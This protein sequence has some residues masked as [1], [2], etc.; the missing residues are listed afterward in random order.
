VIEYGPY[1]ALMMAAL[2]TYLSRAAGV[3]L[4]E[5]LDPRSPVMAWFGCIAYALVAAL[6]ARLILLPGGPLETTSL[7]A[8]LL[9][10]G[11]AL[12][13]FHFRRAGLLAGVVA[14]AGCLAAATALG[15]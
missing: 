15:L 6:V 14:G 5:R 3:A 2:A 7:A 10:T 4:A 12:G 8:R 13:A 1:A 9:A 11:A